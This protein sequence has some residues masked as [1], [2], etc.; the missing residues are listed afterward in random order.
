MRT[1]SA[2]AVGRGDTAAH[3]AWEVLGVPYHNRLLSLDLRGR[4]IDHPHSRDSTL[5]HNLVRDRVSILGSSTRA[6][7][8]VRVEDN[9]TPKEEVAPV[10]RERAEELVEAQDF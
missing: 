10:V 5:S 2:T 7:L 6:S 1:L 4:H 9:S 3:I 8:R